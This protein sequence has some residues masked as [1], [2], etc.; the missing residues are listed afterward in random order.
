VLRLMHSVGQH[1]PCSCKVLGGGREDL[2]LK[3]QIVVLRV[4]VGW[5]VRLLTLSLGSLSP[6]DYSNRSCG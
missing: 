5:I 2:L 6:Y 3:V 1:P 4:V